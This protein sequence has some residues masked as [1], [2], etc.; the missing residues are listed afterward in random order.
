[1]SAA[2]PLKVVILRLYYR[3]VNWWAWRKHLPPG[4]QVREDS[5][6]GPAGSIPIRVY[7]ATDTPRAIIVY[8]HG[9]GW[10]IGD[11]RTHDPF[12]RKL[13]LDTQSRVIAV[14]YRLAPE[15]AFPAAPE[16][17]LAAV[18]WVLDQPQNSILNSNYNPDSLPVFVAGDSAGGNLSAIVAHERPTQLRGQLLIYPATRHYRPYTASHHENATGYGLTLKLMIW[19]WDSYLYNSPVDDSVEVQ[20][21]LASPSHRSLHSELPAALVITAGLDPL[22]DEGIAYADALIAAGVPCKKLHYTDAMHGFL[23]SDGPTPDHEAAMT[24]IRDWLG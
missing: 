6:P 11:L 4:L 24:A 12:C 23:C 7:D 9:G 20:H 16:D 21:P 19:F 14:H 10:V 15:H 17:C 5:I 18:D 3:I 2:N 13:A 22:R 8:F 1:V